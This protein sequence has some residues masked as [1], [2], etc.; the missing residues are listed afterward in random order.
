MTVTESHL[1]YLDSTTLAELIKHIRTST[2][3]SSKT[4]NLLSLEWILSTIL[5]AWVQHERM[6]VQ[7]LKTGFHHTISQR[8]RGNFNL[9]FGAGASPPQSENRLTRVEFQ[10]A[11]VEVCSAQ[12]VS[13]ITEDEV[14]LVWNQIQM[15]QPSTNIMVS[16]F[17][18]KSGLPKPSPKK[19]NPA[20][21]LLGAHENHVVTEA[22]FVSLVGAFIRSRRPRCGIRTRGIPIFDA[23]SERFI[24]GQGREYTPGVEMHFK[25][26]LSQDRIRSIMQHRQ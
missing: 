23:Q 20:L 1:E 5:Y 16:S 8:P 2:P 13:V 10:S 22:A 6:F 15:Q 21:T 9:N 7:Q 14:E 19:P 3:P 18:R 11:F 4:P 26:T 25:P 24:G 17:V 12:D